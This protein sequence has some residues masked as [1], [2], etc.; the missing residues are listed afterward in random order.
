MENLS[1]VRIKKEGNRHFENLSDPVGWQEK[2]QFSNIHEFDKNRIKSSCIRHLSPESGVRP[3]HT[4][5]WN[6]NYN[7]N[8]YN[9]TMI[10]QWTTKSTMYCKKRPAQAYTSSISSYSKNNV[11]SGNCTAYTGYWEIYNYLLK[12]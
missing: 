11:S 6:N 2:Q 5:N 7:C 1:G 4:Q 10:D 12:M 3:E 9:N 8:N